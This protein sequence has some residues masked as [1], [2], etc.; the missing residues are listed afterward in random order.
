MTVSVVQFRS[1]IH[2]H[3]LNLVKAPTLV[4]HARNDGEIPL[5]SGREFATGI[6]GARFVTLESNNHILLEEEP[7]FARFLREVDMFLKNPP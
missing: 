6:P 3:R 1:G 2:S 7:S 4:L 5:A